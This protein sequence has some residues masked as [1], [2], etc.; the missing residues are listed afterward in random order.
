MHL[1]ESTYWW[2]SPSSVHLMKEKSLGSVC[3]MGGDSAL[4][5]MS[6]GV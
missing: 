6:A 4:V 1:Q 5:L 3:G 2:V